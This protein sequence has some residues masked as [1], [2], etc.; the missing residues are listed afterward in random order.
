MSC[1][2]TWLRQAQCATTPAILI[3]MRG[4]HWDE[5]TLANLLHDK[6]CKENRIALCQF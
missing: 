5:P 2:S 4:R 1:Y 6:V 3:G